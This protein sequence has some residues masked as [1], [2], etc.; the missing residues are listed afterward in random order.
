[1]RQRAPIVLSITALVVA[2]LA[3]TPLGQATAKKVAAK[4]PPSRGPPA[5]RGYRATRTS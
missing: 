1:M 5:S 4:F 3:A 2:V